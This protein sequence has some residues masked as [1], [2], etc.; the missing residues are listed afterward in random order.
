MQLKGTTLMLV[1]FILQIIAN[2][3]ILIV[4]PPAGFFL[5][6]DTVLIGFAYFGFKNGKKGW[7][8]FA[9]IYSI[10]SIIFALMGGSFSIG[11]ILMLIAG[12]LAVSDNE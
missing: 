4:L 10:L 11:G 12:I 9:I 1:A 6:I 3:L 7:A 8:T 2:I 5:L